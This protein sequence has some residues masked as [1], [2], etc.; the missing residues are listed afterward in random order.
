MIVLFYVLIIKNVLLLVWLLNTNIS[1]NTLSVTAK[2]GFDATIKDSLKLVVLL[3]VENNVVAKQ[4]NY[5]HNNIDYPGN[6][7]YAAGDTIVNFVHNGVYKVSPTTINGITI[8]ADKQTKDAM[9]T[10]Q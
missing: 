6:P 9:N 8:D 2:T 4:N 5:Y 7:F 3:V 10:L 1:G